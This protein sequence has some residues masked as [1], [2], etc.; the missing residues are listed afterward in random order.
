MKR[1]SLA[2][3]TVYFTELVLKKQADISKDLTKGF[4]KHDF[5]KMKP[6]IKKMDKKKPAQGGLFSN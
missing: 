5:I 4:Q 1:Y 2:G 6:S 3:I